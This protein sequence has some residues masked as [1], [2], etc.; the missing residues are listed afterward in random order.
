MRFDET[1]T[2]E[3]LEC[4]AGWEKGEPPETF[5][6]AIEPGTFLDIFPQES[7]KLK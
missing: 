4:T 2:A 3:P 6:T 5:P 7:I 1:R